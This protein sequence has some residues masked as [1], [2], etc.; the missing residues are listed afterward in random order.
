VCLHT[1]QLPDLPDLRCQHR[2]VPSRRCGGGPG[3]WR[4]GPGLSG[5]GQ[6]SV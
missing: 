6:L 1:D 4:A 2:D 5:R 3:L